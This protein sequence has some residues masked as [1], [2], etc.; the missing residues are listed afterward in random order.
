MK[1]YYRPTR[2]EISLDALQHNLQAFRRHLPSQVEMMAV[3]KA[4]GYGHGAIM[5]AKEALRCGVRYL[6]VAVFDEALELRRAGI[7]API[8]VLGYSPVGAVALAVQYDIALTVFNE[9]MLKQIAGQPA[10]QE[11]PLVVHIKVDTGM[12]RLGPHLEEDAIRLIDQALHTE[13]IVVEGVFTHYAR[14]DA[15]DKTYTLE[16]HRRFKQVVDHC[17]AQ[18]APIRFLHAGNSATALDVPELAFNMVR[19]GVSMYGMYPSDEVNR[20]AVQ[21]KP[22]M[23]L[24]TEVVHL[25]QMAEGCGV[26]YG[27]R[28]ITLDQDEIATLPIGYADGYSRTLSGS[29]EALIRGRR[30]PVVGN[31]C[32]DQCMLN[33]S[34]V[35]AAVGDEV[36]LIGQ[37]GNEVILADDLARTMGTI[38]YEITCMIARRVPRIYIRNGAVVNVVNG[39]F[40][41]Q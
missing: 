23:T 1:A 41:S 12:G 8:L 7:A 2:A 40:P 21:L 33:T 38:N 27:S 11:G 39:L 18:G 4:D 30:V 9:E 14:A 3:V 24:K 5:I 10:L 19:I 35:P 13:G 32:M 29:A 25:K 37:Q 20:Q 22:V 26:G 36:V 34:G 16:Q 31:I 28:Y 15:L 17:I 6:A